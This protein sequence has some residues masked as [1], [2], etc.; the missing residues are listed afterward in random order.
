MAD[1]STITIL[2]DLLATEQRS[3]APR[4]MESTVFVS[5]LSIHENESLRRAAKSTIE[6]ERKLTELIVSLGGAPGPRSADVMTAHLHF[7]EVH[8]VLPQLLADRQSLVQRYSA[9]SA[10]LSREPRA[11]AVVNEILERHRTEAAELQRLSEPTR[12]AG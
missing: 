12:R 10:K 5:K 1:Q 3:I 4:L 9:A 2:R 8:F 11:A 6:N 7:L